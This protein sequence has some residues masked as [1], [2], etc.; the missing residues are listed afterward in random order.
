M[1]DGDSPNERLENTQRRSTARCLVWWDC[2]SIKDT[3]PVAVINE[4]PFTSR[5]GGFVGLTG[6]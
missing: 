3:V 4:V 5:G 2:D 1:V 6:P